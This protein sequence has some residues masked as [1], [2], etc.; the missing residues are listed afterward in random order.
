MA[1]R[2]K[3]E[4]DAKKGSGKCGGCSKNVKEGVSCEVC[5]GCYHFK[6][7]VISEDES[8][9]LAKNPSLHWYCK[10][11]HEGV[12]K[13]WK[14]M[15]EG[16]ELME[17]EM[18]KLKEEMKGLKEIVGKVE[19]LEKEMDLRKKE[20]LNIDKGCLDMAAGVRKTVD[21]WKKD[22]T[23]QGK[24]WDEVKELEERVMK[25]ECGDKECAEQKVKEKSEMTESFKLIMKEQEEEREKEF[26][27][28][29]TIKEREMRQNMIELMEREKRRNNL[30]I[31]GIDQA[32][33]EKM[34]VDKIFEE[35]V[36]EAGFKYEIIGRVGRKDQNGVEAKCRPLRIK[37][38]EIE[39]KR[40]ILTRAKQLKGAKEEWL[41]S[42][43]VTPDLTRF[44]QDE[45]RM[46][47]GKLKEYRNEGRKNVKIERGMIVIEEGG[48][49]QVLFA[50]E[51]SKQ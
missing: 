11:C 29:K 36:V 45:D 39:K 19:K 47:R 9:A 37:V 49:R 42:V 40:R 28:S 17:R 4:D 5:D 21:E 8:K 6:C 32:R 34:A 35:L 50:P 33:D 27:E 41:H 25:L 23:E 38:E 16:Q 51:T 14:I 48:E 3:I 26:K 24:K 22:K 31:F 1:G 46:L 30:V 12:I 18:T 20:V 13:M 15:K 43:Y 2:G 10:G 7:A 44:Q